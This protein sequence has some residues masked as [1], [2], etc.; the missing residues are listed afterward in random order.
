MCGN[1]Y[2]HIYK[3]YVHACCVNVVEMD[4][5]Y[6]IYTKYMRIYNYACILCRCMYECAMY[7]ATSSNGAFHVD[8]IM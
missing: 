5:Y 2:V 3:V 8:V 1:V 7:D 4:P 6:T